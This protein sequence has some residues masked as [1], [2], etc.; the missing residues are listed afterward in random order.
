MQTSATSVSQVHSTTDWTHVDSKR[1]DVHVI[2]RYWDGFDANGKERWYLEL[3]DGRT[4]TEHDPEY[5]KYGTPH[6]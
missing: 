4:L 6:K 3:S 5:S 1:K 2:K